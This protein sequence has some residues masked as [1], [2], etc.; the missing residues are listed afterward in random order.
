MGGWFRRSGPPVGLGGGEKVLA[1]SV[2]ADGTAL[3]GTRSAFHLVSPGGEAVRIPWA[4]VQAATWDSDTGRFQ[5]SEIGDYGRSRGEWSVELTDAATLLGL[6]NERV[7]A[8]V[9]LQRHVPVAGRRGVRVI[10]RR[11]PSGPGELAWLFEFDE[12]VD[13]DDPVVMAA[14]Q[15]ALVEAREEV[16]EG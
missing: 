1:W 2:S 12:G 15:R 5:I 16:G 4:Q 13:P 8:S 7:T 3:G 11:A 6:V 10:A 9:V 14:A